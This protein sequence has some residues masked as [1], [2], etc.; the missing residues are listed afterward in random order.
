[1]TD[2]LKRWTVTVRL[3]APLQVGGG[4]LGMVE[5]TRMLIPGRVVWAALTDAFAGLLFARPERRHYEAIGQGIGPAGE[6]FGPWL[7]SV[8]GGD[9]FRAPV[10][11]R[12][13][14]KW[15]RVG[16]DDPDMLDDARMQSC[17]L[18]G[19]SGQATDPER[20][21]TGDETLHETDLISPV[22]KIESAPARIG[23]TPTRFRGEFNV[24][25]AL[26]ILGN[27]TVFDR[28]LLAE[29]LNVVRI[30]GGRT[31]G[32]GAFQ[33]EELRESAPE[34]DLSRT[35]CDGVTV[36]LN[37]CEEVQSQH[38]DRADGRAHLHVLRE[39]CPERG[40]GRALTRP[41][42]CWEPGTRVLGSLES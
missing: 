6:R 28:D 29:A 38:Q 19:I 41:V 18:S 17:L 9:S 39:Y 42:L 12:G 7:P 27:R 14:R 37:D 10:F 22:V 20:G 23:P 3:T 16:E 5:R 11:I 4:T 26:T 30:G 21:A 15:F 13:R 2:S 35:R 31:R 8:D 34:A 40:S 36:L 24:P 1:M 25:T 32:W 33:L